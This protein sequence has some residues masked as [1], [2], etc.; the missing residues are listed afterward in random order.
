MNL[1][2]FVIRVMFDGIQYVPPSQSGKMSA[3]GNAS[4]L[5][6]LLH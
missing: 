2:S 3:T 6:T 1:F 4:F 5:A